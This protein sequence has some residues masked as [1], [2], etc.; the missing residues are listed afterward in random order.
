M[1]RLARLATRRR[2]WVIV[3]ALVLLPV[4]GLLGGSAEE[5]LSAGGLA[6][7]G[8]PST[9]A[10]ALLLRDFGAGS[11][12][13]LLL[14]TAHRGSVD[15]AAVAAAGTALTRRLVAEPG[16]LRTTSYWTA[17]R[18]PGLRSR[19][20]SQALVLAR[21]G[22]GD[23]A[24]RSA[25]ARLTPRYRSTGPLLDVGVGG[26]AETERQI[27]V[28]A[29]ADLGRSEAL[30]FPVTLLCLLLVFG[31]V[32]AAGLP[33][34]VGLVAVVGTLAVLRLLAGVTTVS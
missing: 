19:D 9:R 2:W 29:K 30:S 17:G 4:C 18:A 10:E 33:L 12:N 25:V 34:A 21:I 1:R 23:D 20:G 16:M 32:V 26:P 27:A 8:A 31:G 6:D 14:V 5:H 7:P 24:V 15:A 11:P 13:L 3:A 22:G 28:Q